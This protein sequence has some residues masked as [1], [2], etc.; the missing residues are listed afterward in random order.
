MPSVVRLGMGQRCRHL[1]KFCFFLP[2]VGGGVAKLARISPGFALKQLSELELALNARNV[3]YSRALVH[4]ARVK[5]PPFEP[6]HHPELSNIC[7]TNL[8]KPWTQTPPNMALFFS[9]SKRRCH[10]K[11]RTERCQSCW[12][13]Q[14][15]S[16]SRRQCH[17][18]F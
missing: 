7:K 4:Y 16:L 12:R 6:P 2:P 8:L 9:A 13:Y 17:L 3:S 18:L 15:P 5:F 1:L 14:R 10:L 11:D